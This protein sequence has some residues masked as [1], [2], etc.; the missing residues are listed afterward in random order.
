MAARRTLVLCAILLAAITA[1]ARA[2]QHDTSWRATAPGDWFDSANWSD[3]A[4]IA[5]DLSSGHINNGGVARIYDGNAFGGGWFSLGDSGGDSGTL[6]IGGA[7]SFSSGHVTVGYYGSGTVLQTGGVHNAGSLYVGD[8]TA[9]TYELS[10]TGQLLVLEEWIGQRGTGSFVHTG[11]T[12]SVNGVLRL[13]GEYNGDG[14]YQLTGDG[15]LSATAEYIGNDISYAPSGK[16]HFV[17]TGGSNTAGYLFIQGAGDYRFS[18]G[19]LQVTRGLQLKG[20]LDLADRPVA[21]AVGASTLVDL[22]G[23]IANAG[24]ASLVVGPN[25]LTILPPGFDPQATFAS[26]STQGLVHT[27]GSDLFIPA[28]KSFAGT[29]VIADHVLVEGLINN[30][31]GQSLGLYGGVSV[32]G[33][34]YVRL[35]GSVSNWWNDFGGTLLVNDDRSGISSGYLATAHELIGGDWINPGTGRFTQTGGT[36]VVDGDLHV[37]YGMTSQGLYQ[38]HAGSLSARQAHVGDDGSTGR[39]VQTGGANTLGGLCVASGGVGTYE[40]SGNGQV[41][42]P[43]L[44]MGDEGGVGRFV[45]SGGTITVGEL[46]MGTSGGD[47]TYEL[48]GG[49]RLSAKAEHVGVDS[50][51]RFVQTGGINAISENLYL[52]ER[53]TEGDATYELGGTGQL[54][55]A[56]EYVGGGE[57]GKARFVQSGGTNTVAG[58]LHV[59]NRDYDDDDAYSGDPDVASAAYTISGGRLQTRDLR[60]DG[61]ALNIASSLAEITVTNSLHLGAASTVSAVQ[62]ATIHMTGSALENESQDASALAGLNRLALVFEGGAEEIDPV[63][64]AGRDLG[65]VPAGLRENFALGMLQLGGNDAGKIR[66]VD[67]FDNQPG[68]EGSEALYVSNLIVGPESSLDLNGLDLYYLS[69]T[70]FP[71]AKIVSNGGSLTRIACVAGDV[72]LDADVDIFDVAVVQTKYGVAGGAHWTDGDFDGNGSVDVFDVALM[73]AA[74]GTGVFGST[75]APVPEPSTGVMM[76]LGGF[77][78]SI[79]FFHGTRR[80]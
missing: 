15:H 63:E 32:S 12:H 33:D 19:L 2:Q 55:A 75:A 3:G 26:F 40:L 13:G 58:L 74:Y 34:A 60:L 62:G 64:V 59:R 79:F 16:G 67:T 43:A 53:G 50:P 68:W 54:S 11:G 21:V 57:G 70:V 77:S 38:F 20:T 22:S 51:G 39:F 25:S 17:Q 6:E 48:S 9:G 52:V 44:W 78:F 36:H 42:A 27:A 24:R 66:L 10:N 46:S 4:P 69:G 8:G 14:T 18:G 65:A 49:G 35:G 7:G 72:D 47:A 80:D 29:G 41:S 56:N 5:G 61:A 37:G 1:S 28:G 30:N 71:G 23:K 45:Q 76:F 31:Q 73:Q